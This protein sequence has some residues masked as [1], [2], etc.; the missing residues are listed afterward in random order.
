MTLDFICWD[1]QHGSASYIKTPN[2]K[3]LVY[4]LGTGSYGEQGAQFSPLIFLKNHYA[5]NSLDQVIISH[6]HK[7]HIDDILNFD[8][9]SPRVLSRPSHLLKEEVMKNIRESDKPFFEKYFE[10][11]ERFSSPVTESSNPQLPNNNGGVLIESFHPV[12]SSQSNINNHS[13]VLSISYANSKI[14]LTGDNE[15]ASWEELLKDTRFREAIKNTD[16]FLAPHHGRESGYYS[17]LF[18]YFNPRLTIISDGDVCDTSATDR[19]RN[20]TKG[21]TVHHRKGGSEER[22]CVTTRKDG[23]IKVQL[24][25]TSADKKP[26]IYVEIE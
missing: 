9:L 6:P 17:D 19:Y 3:H 11:H 15:S 26:F 10:I 13:I 4:D 7:D 25:L 14:L 24:G 23:S 21:W 8:R 18:N 1:V 22:Y 20:V 2:G 12:N 5:I 16:I